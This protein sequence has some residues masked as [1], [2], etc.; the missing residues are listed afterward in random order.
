MLVVV[1]SGGMKGW[2][3]EI[4]NIQ[5]V[6]VE[7]TSVVVAVESLFNIPEGDQPIAV[8]GPAVG[9]RFCIKDDLVEEDRLLIKDR[10]VGIGVA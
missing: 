7:C 10:D 1:T 6:G 3:N 2:G 5:A 9:D 8:E 4:A